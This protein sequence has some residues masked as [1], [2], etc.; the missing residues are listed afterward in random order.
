MPHLQQH[1]GEACDAGGKFQMADIGLHRADAAGA[2]RTLAGKDRLQRVDLHRVA[3]RGSGAMSFD[4]T[5]G[6]RVD[7]GVPIGR[8]QQIGL[9]LRVR[10]GQRVGTAAMVDRR[11]ADDG[12]DR[13]AVAPRIGKA[14]EED[15]ARAF[16]AHIA[17]GL[18]RE[19]LA[20]P[21]RREHAGL[22]EIDMRFR[23]DDGVY[24]ADQRH[25]AVAVADR[26]HR[27]MQG[28]ERAGTG[29]LHRLARPVQIE[30][31]AD[32]VGPDGR[33]RAC[34]HI[35][36]SAR[37]ACHEIAITAGGGADEDADLAPGEI[38]RRVAGILDGV[39]GMHHHQPLLRIHQSGFARRD[40]EEQ[41]VELEHAVDEAAPM[42]VGAAR[43]LPGVAV[44]GAPV[45]AVGRNAGDTVA[46]LNEVLPEGISVAR[47]R[48]G[49]A[50]A[51]DDDRVVCG[52]GV[53]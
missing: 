15:H 2:L 53:V 22:G 32:A 13:V 11:A 3:E 24:P 50:Q 21:V 7:A 52:K 41:R 47:H 19:G 25:L 38:A 31:I 39:P 37:V 10:C 46:T 9:R 12:E 30:E 27:A 29:R 26:A 14:T 33:H 45:P 35:T 23:R 42:D 5:H 28:D 48:E 49:A 44:D 43:F 36:I 8:A 4:I 1:L 20:P 6:R 40:A 16:A 17:I 34:R 18:R 51:D